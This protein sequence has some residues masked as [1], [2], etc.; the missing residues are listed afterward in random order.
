VEDVDE[1]LMEEEAYVYVVPGRSDGAA[2][3]GADTTWGS[4]HIIIGLVD[5]RPMEGSIRP[6]VRSA[7]QSVD[8]LPPLSSSLF[9]FVG[10]SSRA[11][12]S[13]RAWVDRG[14]GDR[15][16][17]LRLVRVCSA[18]SYIYGPLAVR[19]KGVQHAVRR[20]ALPTLVWLDSLPQG[21]TGKNRIIN[22]H[23]TPFP[24]PEWWL[25][26]C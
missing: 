21:E 17:E 14:G 22:G 25:D 11:C 8:S 6:S 26:L 19:A 9:F 3:E 23:P 1:D 15:G 16:L 13:M 7:G 4:R 18:H 12:R 5:G 24:A 20:R 10:L 2:Q